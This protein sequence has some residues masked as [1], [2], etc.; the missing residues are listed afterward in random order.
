KKCYECTIRNGEWET[1][2]LLQPSRVL[3]A[4]KKYKQ[5]F[6]KDTRGWGEGDGYFPHCDNHFVIEAKAPW[7]L[8]AVE[9]ADVRRTV[10][11]ERA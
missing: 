10:K 6:S 4:F 7:A 8:V 3:F 11:D 5:C 1:Y 9:G 2:P